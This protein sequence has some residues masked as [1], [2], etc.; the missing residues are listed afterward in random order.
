[1]HSAYWYIKHT[2]ISEYL[3]PLHNFCL[4]VSCLCHD[5]GHTGR[6]NQFEINTLSKYAIKY[7]DIS[8]LEQFHAYLAL[9][10]LMTEKSN[11]I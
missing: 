2:R 3:T 10:I 11:I 9:R 8:V 1:M 5:I 7:H 4:V 6:T